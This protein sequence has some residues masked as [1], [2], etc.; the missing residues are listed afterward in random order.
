MHYQGRH[1]QVGKRPPMRWLG[2]IAAVMAGALLAPVAFSGPVV[3]HAA[4]TQSAYD[5]LAN[6]PEWRLSAADPAVAAQLAN[7]KQTLAE[8]DIPYDP[9][10]LAAYRVPT[11]EGF[12]TYVTAAPETMTIRPNP[13]LLAHT[14]EGDTAV[15]PAVVITRLIAPDADPQGGPALPSVMLLWGAYNEAWDRLRELGVQPIDVNAFITNLYLQARYVVGDP[16]AVLADIETSLDSNVLNA[17][18]IAAET[19]DRAVET[20]YATP[21]KDILL[22][23]IFEAAGPTLSTVEEL[24]R[25]VVDYLVAFDVLG[26]VTTLLDSAPGDPRGKLHQVSEM[27]EGLLDGRLPVDP[28]TLARMIEDIAAAQVDPLLYAAGLPDS[29][30]LWPSAIITEVVPVA[31]AAPPGP[32]E[33]MANPNLPDGAREEHDGHSAGWS[34]RNKNCF[35]VV[36]DAFKR[37]VCWRIDG[38]DKDNDDSRNFWQLHTDVS[39]ESIGRYMDR[40]WVEAKPRP[41]GAT[42]QSWDAMPQPSAD[43]GGSEGCTTQGN[44]FEVASGAPIQ[45]GFGYYWERTTCE[46]YFP[47]AYD[48]HGHWASIWE[49]N[50]MIHAGRRRAVMVKT[51]VKTPA[52]KGVWWDLLTGQSTRR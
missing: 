12:T 9:D 45:V 43:F 35:D 42:N 22:D 48:D 24:E 46:S 30:H 31:V 41:D 37:L 50:P 18:R 23:R 1:R 3:A 7:L 11:V 2:S 14:P 10:K 16:E 8:R 6:H 19:L 15:D 25:Y 32:D 26:E 33:I 17:E 27:L 20:L 44:T 51:P 39:G 34:T 36:T 38:Q 5:T 47:R 40:M 28:L 52:D 29:K 13:A 21:V 4:T 49:G